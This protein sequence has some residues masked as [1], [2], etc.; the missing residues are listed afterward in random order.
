MSELELMHTKGGAINA[1]LIN[2]VA[3]IFTVFLDIGR[4]IGSAIN[5]Y[6]NRRSC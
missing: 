4:N 2:S 3:R 6:I 1:S 5:Y